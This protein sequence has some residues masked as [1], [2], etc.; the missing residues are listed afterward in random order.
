MESVARYVVHAVG[1]IGSGTVPSGL[2]AFMMPAT[3]L[4]LRRQTE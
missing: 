4:P 3:G 2:L 1:G